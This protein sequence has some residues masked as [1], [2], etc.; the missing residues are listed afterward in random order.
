M[1]YGGSRC[2]AEDMDTGNQM[3]VVS[4]GPDDRDA[5]R[6]Q[7]DLRDSRNRSA[8]LRDRQI[9]QG[10]NDIN[11]LGFAGEYAFCKT[12]NLFLD[13][14]SQPRSGGYDCVA[15]NGSTVDVKS[16]WGSP[17]ERCRLIVKEGDL[18]KADVFVCA[19]VAHAGDGLIVAL[20]GWAT[21]TMLL[22]DGLHYPNGIKNQGPHAACWALSD[23]WRF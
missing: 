10:V 3:I 12:F 1:F 16:R 6:R 22:T 23:F 17:V 8:G 5:I 20:V 11:F 4:L 19:Q 18:H 13:I 9:D 2:G 7:A 21:N 15:M 14:T